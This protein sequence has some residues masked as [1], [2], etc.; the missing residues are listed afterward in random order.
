MLKALGRITHNG[1]T[2]EPYDT[3]EPGDVRCY[4][5][6]PPEVEESLIE[7]GAAV[8]VEE[9]EMHKVQ[10]IAK[11]LKGYPADPDLWSA[12]GYPTLDGVERYFPLH[13]V[14]KKEIKVIWDELSK[15]LPDSD[16]RLDLRIT[17]GGEDENGAAGRSRLLHL[18]IT[19]MHV[20]DPKK[21][22]PDKWTRGGK[23]EC[24]WLREQLEFYVSGADRDAA[25]ARYLEGS[26]DSDDEDD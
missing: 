3:L 12:A 2:L 14:T 16:P 9:S 4:G 10:L 6:F 19:K 11:C 15:K 23:P 7:C 8:E 24:G 21:E 26:N 5:M 20:A 22:D 18:E 1:I 17:G 13:G 25:Y